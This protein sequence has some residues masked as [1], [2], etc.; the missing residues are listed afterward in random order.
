MRLWIAPLALAATAAAGSRVRADDDSEHYMIRAELGAEYDSNAHR[1]ENLAGDTPI[2]PVG[3]ALGRGVL[4]ASLADAVDARQDVTMSATAAGKLF[5]N[6]AARDEDVAVAATSLTWRRTL[7]DRATLAAAGAYYEAF[8][9]RPQTISYSTE[10]RDFRSLAATL[11]LGWGLGGRAELAGIAGYRSFLFK[12]DR[13][14]DFDAPLAALELR[15]ARES[16]DGTADWDGTVSGGYE[17]RAFA[18][19]AIINPCQPPSSVGA[20]CLPVVGN[21]PRRDHSWTGRFDVT[22]TGRVLVGAGYL[23][24]YNA[25]NSFDSTVFQHF[26]TARLAAALPWGLFA[27]ARAELLFASYPEPLVLVGTMAVNQ[28]TIEDENHSSARVDVSRALGDRL[29]LIARYTFYGPALSG[30]QISYS[31]QTASLSLAFT[32]EK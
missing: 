20:G 26:V 30:S 29:Q 13:D 1:T 25:S 9:R 22:R 24:H 8:Q 4:T 28:T 7:S 32:I 21:D 16:A 23:F 17:R 18:G 10:Q 12:P 3:S 5:E 27:T 15:W 2:A 14:F 6:P 11:R 19:T 31:R